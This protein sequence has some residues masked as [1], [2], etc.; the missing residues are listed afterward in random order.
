MNWKTNNPSCQFWARTPSTIFDSE[1]HLARFWFFVLLSLNGYNNWISYLFCCFVPVWVNEM[2]VKGSVCCPMGSDKQKTIVFAFMTNALPPP[3][4]AS[5]ECPAVLDVLQQTNRQFINAPSKIN[6]SF[7]IWLFEFTSSE[8][9]I[10]EI[11]HFGSV[12]GSSTVLDSPLLLLPPSREG[13]MK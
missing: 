12:Q 1:K 4:R 5:L 13:K 8:L 2:L 6:G 9:F 3:W 7:V 11:N 10:I